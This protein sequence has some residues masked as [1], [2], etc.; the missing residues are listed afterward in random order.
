[1]KQF[2]LLIVFLFGL[3][4][5]FSQDFYFSQFYSS[6]LTLNPAMTGVI[7][8]NYRFSAVYRN[9]LQSLLPYSTYSGSFDMH[10]L[11]SKLKKD[12]FAGGIVFI[13]DELAGGYSDNIMGQLSVSFQKAIGNRNYLSI[14]IQ[15]G[16]F[17]RTFAL[18]N[19]QYGNQWTILS[20][21]DAGMPNNENFNDMVTTTFDSNAGLLWYSYLGKKSSLFAGAAAFHLLEPEDTYL[22]QNS[23]ISRRMVYH[24]GVRMGFDNGYSIIPNVIYMSQNKANLLIG[25]LNVEYRIQN[26]NYG[27]KSGIWYKFSDAYI[28][29]LGY[30]YNSME[31]YF[32]YDIVSANK[33]MEGV[34]GGFEI[35]LLYS[36]FLRNFVQLKNNPGQQY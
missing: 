8:G 25:G 35:S 18:N 26:K 3:E 36:G 33:Y 24:G 12:I 9:Q 29:M 2:L 21:F 16:M 22:S 6:P 4:K 10:L 17:Q 5:V 1:M 19:F 23:K 20:G 11:R 14:G 7:A 31:L 13:K 34:K 15:A 32:S 30:F 28:I 27:L